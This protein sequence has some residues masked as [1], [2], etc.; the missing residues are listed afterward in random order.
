MLTLPVTTMQVVLDMPVLSAD[1]A[2]AHYSAMFPSAVVSQTVISPVVS[3]VLITL[4]QH[5]MCP[6]VPLFQAAR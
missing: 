6:V 2:L 4:A 5:P 1:L 3:L